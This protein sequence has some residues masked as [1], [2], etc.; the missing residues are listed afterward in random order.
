MNYLQ[1][2]VGD[3]GREGLRGVYGERGE[4][5]KTIKIYFSFYVSVDE[6]ILI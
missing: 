5:G 1:G 6:V 3:E 2:Q 4:K